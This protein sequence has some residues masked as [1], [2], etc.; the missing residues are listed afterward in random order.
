MSSGRAQP[1]FRSV[2]VSCGVIF[3]IDIKMFFFCS[4]ALDLHLGLG[5]LR[6]QEGLDL[7]ENTNVDQNGKAKTTSNES[8]VHRKMSYSQISHG[9]L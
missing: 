8:L 6:L 5:I 9:K 7:K 4:T 3:L 1:I 2:T